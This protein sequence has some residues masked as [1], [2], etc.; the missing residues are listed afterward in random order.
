MTKYNKITKE[1]ILELFKTKKTITRKDVT[2]RYKCS[3]YLTRQLIDELKESNEI[4]ITNYGYK[5][6]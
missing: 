2:D 3:I 1:Q 4:K 5:K 6:T